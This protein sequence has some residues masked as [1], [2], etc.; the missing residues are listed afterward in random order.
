MSVDASYSSDGRLYVCFEDATGLVS[1]EGGT[2]GPDGPYPAMVTWE[3]GAGSLLADDA[4]DVGLALVRLA[5]DADRL[6]AAYAASMGGSRVDDD[7]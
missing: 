2:S 4:R 3:M 5:E 6:N 7:A 1:G